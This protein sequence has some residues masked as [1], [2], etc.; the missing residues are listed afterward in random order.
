MFKTDLLV[1]ETKESEFLFTVGY[2]HG[3]GFSNCYPQYVPFQENDNIKFQRIIKEQQYFKATNLLIYYSPEDYFTRI[4]QSQSHQYITDDPFLGKIFRVPEDS[5]KRIIN[6]REELGKADLETL[7]MT[8]KLSCLLGVEM[9]YLGLIGTLTYGGIDQTSDFDLVIYGRHNC[10]NT[11]QKIKELCTHDQYQL[12]K[13]NRIHHRQFNLEGR[14]IDPHFVLDPGESSLLQQYSFVSKGEKRLE[15]T[16]VENSHSCFTPAVYQM[17][18]GYLVTYAIGHR[19]LLEVGTKLDLPVKVFEG[20][21]KC[22]GKPNYF[23]LWQMEKGWIDPTKEKI[24]SVRFHDVP[25]CKNV[26]RI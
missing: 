11:S 24:F 8:K 23:Y 2:L 17:E 13:Y 10:L 1:L 19:M 26:A 12:I 25:R 3:Q 14:I 7:R 22:N 20:T 16:I 9:E 6:P 18:S 5:I 4:K 21:H 15:E